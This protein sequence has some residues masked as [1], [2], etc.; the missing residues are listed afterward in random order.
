M[1]K[2]QTEGYGMKEINGNKAVIISMACDGTL[3][4]DEVVF[5]MVNNCAYRVE[6]LINH[7][8][9]WIGVREVKQG[10]L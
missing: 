4:V 8:G 6:K 2:Y 7:Q 9:E 1:N 5:S 3:A 10:G